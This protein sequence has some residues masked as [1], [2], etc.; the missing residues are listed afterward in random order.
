MFSGACQQTSWRMLTKERVGHRAHRVNRGRGC[1]ACSRGPGPE[2]CNF[3]AAFLC[4]GPGRWVAE[5]CVLQWQPPQV[6][7][8][9]AWVLSLHPQVKEPNPQGCLD[10]F[11]LGFQCALQFVAKVVLNSILSTVPSLEPESSKVV[12]WDL[13]M[14][15]YAWCI[16]SDLT[17]LLG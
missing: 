6:S 5:P 12:G 17:F 9:R 2:Q 4:M 1:T 16:C 7:S 11:L 15:F 3:P 10:G 13:R 14:W 8:Q